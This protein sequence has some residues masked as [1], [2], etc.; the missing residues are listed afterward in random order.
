MGR[1]HSLGSSFPITKVDSSSLSE[2]VLVLLEEDMYSTTCQDLESP[3]AGERRL[4]KELK[5]V[6]LLSRLL[7]SA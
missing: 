1:A 7:E 4:S 6:V 5:D 3:E 2:S